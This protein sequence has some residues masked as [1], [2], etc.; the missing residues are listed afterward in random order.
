[1]KLKKDEQGHVV[2]I[3]DKPVYVG[4]DG[5]DIVFDAPSAVA[6]IS[7]LNAE[8]KNHRLGKEAAEAKLLEFD[9]IDDPVAA[10]KALV[11]VKN[12]DDKKLVEAGKVEEVKREAVAAV[13]AKYKPV[14]EENTKLKTE[15]YSEKVGG[16]FS[17]S[18]YIAE[19][20]A[21]P[22]DLLQARFG[23]N[24]E[25]KE[26][27]IIGKDSAGNP[28]YSKGRPG[29]VAEFEEAIEVLVDQYPQ[30][31]QILKA[32][33]GSGGGA[34]HSNGNVNLGK[35]DLSKLSPVARMNIARGLPASGGN[36]GS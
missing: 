17:R 23:S 15:L 10:K 31:D 7:S 19:K 32:A 2:V 22:A 34:R 9:G 13:E 24:F 8:A 33:S 4:D 11:T 36:I 27:K 1:M 14:V 5:K 3:D 26:G 12:L 20:I 35:E 28:I 21:I 29:E 30:K 25:I 16:A 6:K 18:K